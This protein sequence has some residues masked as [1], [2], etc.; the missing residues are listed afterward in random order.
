MR[1][2]KI[3]SI[4]LSKRAKFAVCLDGSNGGGVETQH[5]PLYPT[6]ARATRV[7]RN[8]GCTGQVVSVP[9]SESTHS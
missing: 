2:V 9:R 5:G 4:N 1:T 8:M 3:T 7:L 6:R